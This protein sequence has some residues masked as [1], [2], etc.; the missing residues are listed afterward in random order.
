MS[1]RFLILSDLHLGKKPERMHAGLFRSLWRRGDHLIINGDCAELHD[2]RYNWEAAR[3]TLRLQELCDNDGVTLTLLAGNHD[4]GISKLRHLFLGNGK[5]LVTHGDAVHPA[6][7]PWCH[8]APIM[9]G[10]FDDA[11][12]ALPVESRTDLEARLRASTHAAEVKWETVKDQV[13]WI[14]IWGLLRQ[15][16]SFVQIVQ[17]WQAF[18]REAA[19]FASEFA[20]SA[21]YVVM[22]HTH[23]QGIWTV[24]DRVVINSGCYEFPGKPRAVVLE[25]NVL[26]V[27]SLSQ[28]R[29]GFQCKPTPLATFEV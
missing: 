26:R 19:K 29:D 8:S 6:I 28:T 13:G 7:A 10:A 16:W 12:K 22:G 17:Y 27:H 9:R 5:V 25:D 18:P 1:E 2:P 24:D 4:P 20:P 14:G 11:M 15:P 23:H 21:K 3:Q